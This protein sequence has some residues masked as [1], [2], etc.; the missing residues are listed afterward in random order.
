M[1]LKTQRIRERG[2]AENIFEEM[3]EDFSN[4]L[5]DINLQPKQDKYKVTPWSIF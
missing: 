4:V 2:W 3:A 5:K 1:K